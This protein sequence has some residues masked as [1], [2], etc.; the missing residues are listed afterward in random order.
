MIQRP[1][2]AADNKPQ[3]HF[4]NAIKVPSNDVKQESQNTTPS[5]PFTF[6]LIMVLVIITLCGIVIAAWVYR[7][8]TKSL[9]QIISVMKEASLAEHSDQLPRILVKSNDE[10]ASIA[11]AYNTMAAALET[12][13]KDQKQANLL[14][15]EQN[16][17]KTKITEITAK[18]QGIQSLPELAKAF[19]TEVTPAVGA[20]YGVLYLKKKMDNGSLCF[21]KGGVYAASHSDIGADSFAYDEGLVGQCAAENKI[22]IVDDPRNITFKLNPGWG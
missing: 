16:W 5:S 1:G 14:L 19:I 11:R 8:I 9:S 3:L 2:T 22:I 12:H 20:R 13:A 4:H 15:Q 17:H 10:M 21:V 6:R 18:Y 7:S